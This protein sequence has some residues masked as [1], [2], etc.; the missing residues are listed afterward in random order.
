MV[1]DLFLWEMEGKK[2]RLL[3]ELINVIGNNE[4]APKFLTTLKIMN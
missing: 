4:V 1:F 2:S 3:K